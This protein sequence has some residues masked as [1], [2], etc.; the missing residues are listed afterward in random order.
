MATEDTSVASDL[1]SMAKSQERI[2]VALEQ[3]AEKFCGIPTKL[4]VNHSEPTKETVVAKP[5]KIGMKKMPIKAGGG[6]TGDKDTVTITALDNST[7]PV[8]FPM[9]GATITA[10]SSDIT[11]LT[12]DAPVG[13]TYGEHF[14]Q[15]GSVT[16][17]ITATF[18][19]GTVLT[20]TDSVVITGQVGSLVAT[21]SLPV[22]GP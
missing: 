6:P 15:P 17:T 7:P 12:I 9:T 10:V 14:L 21:H 8:P 2:A 16:V 5:A 19:D 20:L 22:I 4:V 18:P 1:R 11:T 13:A 3:I